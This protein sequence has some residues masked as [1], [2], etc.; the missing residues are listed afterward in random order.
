MNYQA[1]KILGS[2]ILS[3]LMLTA[4][5][6]QSADEQASAPTESSDQETITSEHTR[7]VEKVWELAGFHNPESVIYDAK[8]DRLYVSNVDGSAVEKDG[9]GGVAVV[10]TAGEMINEAWV[11][12]LNAPKGLTISNDRLYVADIDRL[13]EIDLETG[14]I[15][16]EYNAEGAKFLNDVAARANGEVFVS[17]MMTNQIYRLK[18]GEFSVWLETSDLANPNGLLVEDK[19]LIVGTWGVM[20]E[21]FSTEVPGHLISID[22]ETKTISNIGGGTPIGNMDGVEH[23]EEGYLVTDWISGLLSYVD[24]EGK[25]TLLLELEQGMADHE[26]IEDTDMIF[27]PMMKN[28]TL[29]AYKISH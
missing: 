16:N 11:D 1:T 6:E 2:V 18:D 28:D 3:A 19:Q 24:T 29:L 20:K 10:S 21:D 8:R 7:S 23:Y 22:Y 17:D 15:A 26:V 14:E 27:L 4:C 9:A 25:A 13:L 5:S 12:G